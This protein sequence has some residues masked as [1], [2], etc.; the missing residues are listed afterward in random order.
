M[1]LKEPFFINVEDEKDEENVLNTA[2][3]SFN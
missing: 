3:Y 1:K 2:L